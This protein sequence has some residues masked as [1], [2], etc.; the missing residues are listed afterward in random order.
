[1]GLT[2]IMLQNLHARLDASFSRPEI[3]H[4]FL[5]GVRLFDYSCKPATTPAR[6]SI[7]HPKRLFQ[8]YSF[9]IININ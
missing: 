9:F 7:K 2:A 5:L 8:S 1:M 6:K 3:L 4:Q